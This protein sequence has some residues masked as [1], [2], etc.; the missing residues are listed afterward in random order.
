MIECC[1]AHCCTAQVY[2]KAGSLETA[3]GD[4][5]GKER[6]IVITGRRPSVS[7]S[8]AA[9]TCARACAGHRRVRPHGG[10]PSSDPRL[11]F[12]PTLFPP[13]PPHPTDKPLYDM[14]FGKKVTDVLRSYG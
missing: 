13:H 4:L 10:G 5:A 14:G 1:A 9:H 6:A 2:F 7:A 12:L 3:L 8:L 11:S